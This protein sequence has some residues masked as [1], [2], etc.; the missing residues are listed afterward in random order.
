MTP[1]AAHVVPVFG[2][3]QSGIDHGRSGGS[4]SLSA[5]ENSMRALLSPQ[6]LHQPISDRRPA[7]SI[8]DKEI[9]SYVKDNRNIVKAV[10]DLI[11]KRLNR[12]LTEKE[13]KSVSD[14]TCLSVTGCRGFSVTDSYP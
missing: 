12:N 14:S 10:F 3:D 13:G 1:T 5:T 6:A 11:V 4:E 8:T 7:P 9:E 2:M